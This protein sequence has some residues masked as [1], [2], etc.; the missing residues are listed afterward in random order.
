MSLRRSRRVAWTVLPLCVLA[1][2][3]W[4]RHDA[5]GLRNALS[6]EYWSDRLT[7]RHLYDPTKVYLKHGDPSEPEVALTFDDGPHPTSALRILDVLKRRH[8]KATF[9]LVGTRIK[10]HPEIVRRIVADGHEVGNHTQDHLRLDTLRPDQIGKELDNCATNFERAVPGQKMELFRPP[11]MRFNADVIAAA[12]KHGYTMV[13]WN[14]AAKDF[15]SLSHR[16]A[17]PTFV[18]RRVVDQVE[19]GSII[20]LHDIPAT[21]EVLDQILDAIEKKGFRFETVSEMLAKVRG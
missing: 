9:F 2:V 18:E 14:D 20:L 6:P 4:L 13:G 7:G 16:H 17:D 19:S 8:V 15:I 11:G 21:A 5:H 12:K 10:E 1:G 3:L